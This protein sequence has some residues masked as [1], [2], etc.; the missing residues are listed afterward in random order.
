MINRWV[1]ELRE[2]RI[3]LNVDYSYVFKYGEFRIICHEVFKDAIIEYAQ[4]FGIIITEIFT[5][6]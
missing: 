1:E 2:R 4:R 5:Y 3:K 6:K